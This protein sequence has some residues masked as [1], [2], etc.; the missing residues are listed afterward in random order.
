MNNVA[1]DT[2]DGTILLVHVQ[3]KAARTECVGL[4][5]G[6]LKIRVAAPPVDGA[7]NEEL[8]RFLAER[9][10]L[11]RA[12]IVIQSGAAGRR[13]RVHLNGITAAQVTAF[14]MPDSK[15]GGRS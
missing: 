1:Q 14:L 12:G 3:P 10:G 13:K 5:G 9:C 15:P 8:S 4:Y 7:A 11:P 2:G 6:A